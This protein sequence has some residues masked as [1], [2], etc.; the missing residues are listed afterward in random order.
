MTGALSTLPSRMMAKRRLMFRPE[1]SS[2]RSPPMGV[3]SIET[4]QPPRPLPLSSGSALASRTMSP[5]ISALEK[6]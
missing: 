3:I 2:K 6:R 1:I 4:C 5:V